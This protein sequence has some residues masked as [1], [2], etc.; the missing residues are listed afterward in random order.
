ILEIAKVLRRE[1]G[2]SA[3][4]VPRFQAPDWMV[5][6]AARHNPMLRYALPMLGK[7]RRATSA[8]ARQRL[9]W[10]P[11]GNE[12]TILATAESLIRL[13]LVKP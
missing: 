3:R 7:I 1:L 11:R 10:T 2:R 9:G 8:K 5:R 4:R 13:G 6:L 12:E